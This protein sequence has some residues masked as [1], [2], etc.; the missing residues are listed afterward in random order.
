[1]FP[2]RNIISS[3]KIYLEN[4]EYKQSIG[5]KPDGLW[6]ACGDSWYN[7]IKDEKMQSV[8]PSKYLYKLLLYRGVIN[9]KLL[10]IDTL[11]KF[12]SFNKKYGTKNK[13]NWK[14]V[15]NDYSGIEI[16]PHFKSRK[17]LWYLTWD[18]A[19][20]C[21]WDISIIKNLIIIPKVL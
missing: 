8:Y 12:D 6:Y 4:K 15:M 2:T 9:D 11:K 1:M 16:C 10:V 21:I 20:G 3:K 5:F 13:I 19:S 18:I 7:W 17:N 14:K